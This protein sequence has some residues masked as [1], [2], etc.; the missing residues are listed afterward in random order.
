MSLRKLR[1]NSFTHAG[2]HGLF[3]MKN[4]LVKAEF[5]ENLLVGDSLIV[6]QDS[7]TTKV[8]KS[9]LKL[10]KLCLHF[11]T[12][13]L[14]SISLVTETGWLDPLTRS[15]TIVVNNVSTSCCK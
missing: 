15:G 5:A 6:S 11:Q 13:R 12:E 9:F 1:I 10:K 14:V 3:I 2:T 4:G 8:E 7:N